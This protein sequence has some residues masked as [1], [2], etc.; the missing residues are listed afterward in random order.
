M[1]YSRMVTSLTLSLLYPPTVWVDALLS[2]GYCFFG[3]WLIGWLVPYFVLSLSQ[4]LVS[5][6]VYLCVPVVL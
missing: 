6:V 5:P 2:K 4:S 1:L 3:V